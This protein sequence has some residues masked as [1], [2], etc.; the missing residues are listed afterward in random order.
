MGL[1]LGSTLSAVEARN[2]GEGAKAAA[3]PAR[4][5]TRTF[6]SDIRMYKRETKGKSK[7]VSKW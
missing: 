2:A 5:R 1:G 4:A 3:D 7:C 6:Y